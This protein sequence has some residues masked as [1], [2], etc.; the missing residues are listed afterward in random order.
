MKIYIN[1]GH[2]VDGT[3]HGACCFGLREA[4]IA[5]RIGQRVE[6]YLRA[7]GY[8][9]KLGQ[10]DQLQTICDD[11]NAWYADYFVSIHCNAFD[12]NAKG[13]ETYCYR[14]ASAGRKLAESIHA[15]ITSSLPITNRG[16]KEEGFYVLANTDMPAVLV[17]TAFID[18][19]DDAELLRT[20]EDDFARAI[21]RGISDFFAATVP[22]AKPLPDVLDLP[23]KSSSTKLS[24]H[25]DAS[26]FVCHCCGR[27]AEKISPRLIELLEQL[28]AKVG[29]PIHINCGYRCPKHN[30]EVGGVV[31]SQH[32]DGTAA[33]IFIPQI[34]YD[35][36]KQIIEDL[37]FDGV[38]LYP[39]LDSGGNWFIHVDTRA[40]GICK[41][42]SW[43]E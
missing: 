42:Y 29:K 14:G 17:E 6:S 21:A 24:A 38:G 1:P 34:G 40:G 43:E 26:E 30:A 20:R 35:R 10:F 28:R 11:A 36:A 12:G 41:R 16:V 19:A 33:D 2:S 5:L 15:Q 9:V 31:N 3:D 4:D 32:I 37:P 13:T 8:T 27:G 7:V 23:N 39:P 22:K 25:F 18:N